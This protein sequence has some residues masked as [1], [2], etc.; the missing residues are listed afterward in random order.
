MTQGVGGVR[1][2][3]PGYGGVGFLSCSSSGFRFGW[4]F[5]SCQV[6]LLLSDWLTF[7]S[8]QRAGEM[9]VPFQG[10]P[11]TVYLIFFSPRGRTHCR[12]VWP[13]SGLLAH[14]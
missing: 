7:S 2:V 13:L 6:V 3:A 5:L 1:E 9:A 10:H 11:N 4:V 14:F 12:V 8:L